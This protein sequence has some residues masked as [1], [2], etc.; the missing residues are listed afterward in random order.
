MIVVALILF[1]VTVCVSAFTPEIILLVNVGYLWL[2]SI[3]RQIRR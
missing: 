3:L 1:I 2:I